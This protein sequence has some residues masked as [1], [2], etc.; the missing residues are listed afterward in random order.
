M[1]KSEDRFDGVDNG[2]IPLSGKPYKPI[3]NAESEQAERR[4]N[5]RARILSVKS[6]CVRSIYIF[7]KV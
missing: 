7:D 3:E 4:A 2:R 1:F 6:I 5:E